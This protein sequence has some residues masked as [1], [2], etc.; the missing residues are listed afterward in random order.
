M[1]YKTAPCEPA[2]PCQRPF[3]VLVSRA[4]CCIL[5]A[6]RTLTFR[7]LILGTLIAVPATQAESA[8]VTNL[9]YL[10][11][12]AET[13]G[14]SLGRPTKALPTPDGRAVLFLRAGARTPKLD[15]YEFDVASGVTR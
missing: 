9:K 7:A 2:Y 12:H 11:D 13:R 8:R 5:P 10:R 3:A 6:M 14:F 15:L 1:P 4:C